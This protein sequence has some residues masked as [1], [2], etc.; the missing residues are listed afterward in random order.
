MHNENQ[1]PEP[2]PRGGNPW[3]KDSVQA[4]F[5]L[6]DAS[7]QTSAYTRADTW[8]VFRVMSELVE[9]FEQLSKV[10]PAVSVFGSSRMSRSDP[11]YDQARHTARLLAKN[12]LAVITGGGGGV[13]EAANRGAQEGGGVSIGLNI[14]LPHEQVPNE[15]LDEMLEFHYFFVRKLMF[16][17]YSIGFILFPGGYGTMDEMFESLTLLQTG[18]TRNFGVVLFGSPYWE[19]LMDW[20]REMMLA[21]GYI[22]P[23][24]VDLFK[25]T[26][27]PQAAVEHIL[28]RL[29]AV[30]E[31][32]ARKRRKSSRK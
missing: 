25:L 15:Y 2:E 27:E 17:K 31:G 21:R 26:D 3:T 28:E 30:A 12:N 20:L 4:D 32:E 29:H 10:G 19:R 23:S 13:M 1:S 5:E 8:R 9:G 24:D 14:E 22:S 11:Y 18:K 7:R 16:L 6:L